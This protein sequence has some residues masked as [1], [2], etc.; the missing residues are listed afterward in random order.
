MK[1]LADVKRKKKERKR[2]INQHRSGLTEGDRVN[3]EIF[4]K[5]NL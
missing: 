5:H 4:V 2:D 3:V 1:T